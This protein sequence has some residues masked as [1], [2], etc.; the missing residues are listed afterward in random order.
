MISRRDWLKLGAA[1]ATLDATQSYAMCSKQQLLKQ[2]VLKHPLRLK[3]H[4][5]Q[6]PIMND[7]CLTCQ[8]AQ[9][10]GEDSID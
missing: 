6:C 5:A 9:R 2:P 3:R 10:A 8:Q 7:R 1:G 4:N